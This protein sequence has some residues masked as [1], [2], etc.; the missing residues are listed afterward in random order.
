MERIAPYAFA[1]LMQGRVASCKAQTLGMEGLMAP[2]RKYT[3]NEK[4]FYVI[5]LLIVF[6][7]LVGLVASA[8]VPTGF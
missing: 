6:S 7:M 5:S 1:A 3:R 2:R 8:L 4:I